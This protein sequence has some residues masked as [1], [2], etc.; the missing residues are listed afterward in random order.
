MMRDCPSW[1]KK[2][3][4]KRSA[5]ATGRVY[6]LDAKKT[7]GGNNIIS[8][9]C[10][11]RHE[12]IIVIFDCGATQSFISNKCVQRLNLDLSPIPNTMLVTTATEGSVETTHVCENCPIIVSERTFFVDLIFLPLKAIDVVLGMDW[13]S[14]NQVYIGCREKVIFVPPKT[15]TEGEVFSTLLDSTHQLIQCLFGGEQNFI[16]M[17]STDFKP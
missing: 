11:L 8:G 4:V 16:L 7:Q 13:L 2:E 6:V 17:L 5:P 14:A 9:T 1:K 15:M 3:V 10:Y 12:P